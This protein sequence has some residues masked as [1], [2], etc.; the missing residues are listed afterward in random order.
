MRAIFG[1]ADGVEQL[2]TEADEQSRAAVVGAAAAGRHEEFARAGVEQRAD[3]FAHAVRIGDADDFRRLEHRAAVGE[4]A[5]RRIAP[6]GRC[7]AHV[8]E[9]PFAACREHRVERAFAAV[10]HR[11]DADFRVRARAQDAFGD[12]VGHVFG[13]QRALEGIGCDDDDGNGQGGVL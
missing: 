9:S 4:Q 12:G 3:R 2:E 6:G 13:R 7:A 10:G 11:T 5:G 8:D 1:N